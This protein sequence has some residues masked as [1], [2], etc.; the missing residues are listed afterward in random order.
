[1]NNSAIE[2]QKTVTL[3]CAVNAFHV[4][5]SIIYSMCFFCM[6]QCSPDIERRLCSLLDNKTVPLII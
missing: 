3:A 4:A 2:G 6:L 1:M 5:L